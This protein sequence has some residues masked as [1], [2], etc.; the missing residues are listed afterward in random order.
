MRWP[1]R[2]AALWKVSKRQ[3]LGKVNV[4]QIWSATRHAGNLLPSAPELFF[5]S[6]V[7]VSRFRE[8]SHC[9]TYICRISGAAIMARKRKVPRSFEQSEP[10]RVTKFDVEERFDGS[11][12]EFYQGR[13]KILLDE[14]TVSKHRRRI[15][16]QEKGLQLSDEEILPYEDYEDEDED[17]KIEEEEL[18]QRGVREGFPEHEDDEDDEDESEE[19]NWGTTRADYYGDDVIET[20][21]QAKAEEEEAKRLHLKQMKNMT[22]AD[23]GFD[24]HEWIDDQKDT[25]KR[26]PVTEKLP[27]ARIP[28]NASEEQKLQILVARYPEFL[29]L[30]EDFTGLQELKAELD[31][32][33]DLISESIQRG[34]KVDDGLPVAIKRNALNTYLATISMY[35]AVV[36]T[37]IFSGGEQ[38]RIT[39]MPPPDLHDHPVISA[40]ARARQLWDEVEPLKVCKVVTASE[41]EMEETN[42]TTTSPRK[43]VIREINGHS[44]KADKR[45]KRLGEPATNILNE[46]DVVGMT[47]F[48]N[49]INGDVVKKKKR[50]PKPKSGKAILDLDTLLEQ[51][52]FDP[53]DSDFGDEQPLTKEQYAEKARKRKSLRFYTSQIAS[54]ANKR[55]HASR[56]A[57]G[58]DDLPHKERQKD[59][60][61]RLNREAEARGR[62]N[63]DP[64]DDFD[65]DDDNDNELIQQNVNDDYYNTLLN[66]KQQKKSDKQARTEAYAQAARA[67]ATVYEE[68]T[69]GPDG[70]R[71]ITYAIAKNKG[72]TPKRSKDVRNPRVKKRKKYDEKLKK[73][74][75][76]RPVYKGGEGRGGYRGELT[77]IKTNLVKSTKL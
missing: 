35:L 70:K 20:E 75:S 8:L 23:F 57:G 13:D 53:E 9:L 37:A 3:E 24:E 67:G 21:E 30:T 22:E 4:L 50:K 58:D 49:R 48:E 73:L 32:T 16:D 33:A 39:A 68:E 40:L 10:K 43:P 26:K 18:I 54:K 31:Q 72:L 2:T 66:V 60:I 51:T 38:H 34:A 6:R 64:A 44:K 52:H 46:R 74:N 61:E 47:K 63:V 29:P 59:R 1:T 62:Q 15:L 7:A 25:Q 19:E 42:P 56:D 71:A 69:V 28:E 65:G 55:G 17:D 14:S 5:T 12:D 77:G 45:V 11:D 76:M 27:D 36:S 41:E